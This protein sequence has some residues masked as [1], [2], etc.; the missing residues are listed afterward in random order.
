MLQLLCALYIS[1]LVKD[2]LFYASSKCVC[3]LDFYSACTKSPR[4]YVHLDLILKRTGVH[5]GKLI[6]ITK[7]YTPRNAILIEEIKSFMPVWSLS[8]QCC[9]HNN[10]PV[11]YVLLQLKLVCVCTLLCT[12]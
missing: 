3:C 6:D 4:P 9:V 2:E 11:L 5:F 10:L 8:V 7:R 12:V 1:D